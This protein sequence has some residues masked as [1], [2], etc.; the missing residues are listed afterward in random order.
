VR[1]LCVTEGKVRQLRR[2]SEKSKHHGKVE[3]GRRNPRSQPKGQSAVLSRKS[4][5]RVCGRGGVRDKY[6]KDLYGGVEIRWKKNRRGEGERARGR[7]FVM[8][9]KRGASE[10]SA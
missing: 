2:V 10:K 1:G 4:R 7:Q 8:D 9:R 5:S 6:T 3:G